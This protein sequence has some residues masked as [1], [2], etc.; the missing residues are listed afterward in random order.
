MLNNI[1]QHVMFYEKIYCHYLTDT[2]AFNCVRILK[3][4]FLLYKN[5]YHLLYNIFY[6]YN[7][8]INS[9]IYIN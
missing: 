3:H 8:Y 1:R 9:I 6:F 7:I 5:Y 2:S 4:I